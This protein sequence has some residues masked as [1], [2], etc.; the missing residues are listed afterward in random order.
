MTLILLATGCAGFLVS[1]ALLHA[2]LT[3]MWLRYPVAILSAYAVFLLLLRLWLAAQSRRGDLPDLGIDLAN[4]DPSGVVTG[5]GGPSDFGFGGA[6]DFAGG[7][8]GGAVDGGA[9]AASLLSSG[10]GGGTGGGL[11]DGLNNLDLGFDDEGCGAVLALVVLAL[12]ILAGLVVSFY[13]VWAAPALLAEILVDGLLVA[14]LYK[15][16]KNAERRHWLRAAVRRTIL[17]VVLTVASFTAAGYAMQRAV[18]R[19]RSVGEFWKA[20][21]DD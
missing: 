6:G 10:T 9:E 7:G 11:L 5:G 21:F 20:V 19:A 13:V 17:P 2:G 16:V 4:V 18:P 3:R 12:A 8:A 14:G 15:R 1:F